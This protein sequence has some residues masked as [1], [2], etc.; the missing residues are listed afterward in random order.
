MD[1]SGRRQSSSRLQIVYTI[2]GHF[3]NVTEFWQTTYYYILNRIIVL[4]MDK[5]WEKTETACIQLTNKWQWQLQQV[6][7]LSPWQLSLNRWR[8][9]L[10]RRRQEKDRIVPCPL[11]A[12]PLPL[13]LHFFKILPIRNSIKYHQFVEDTPYLH[14]FQFHNLILQLWWKIQV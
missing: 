9:C 13:K 1:A 6:R 4:G 2:Q 11:S 14:N 12:P 10:T 8:W 7:K 3:G 5:G